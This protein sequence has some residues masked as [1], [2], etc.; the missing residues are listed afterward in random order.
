MTLKQ[1]ASDIAASAEAE[2]K[3]TLKSAKAEAK[4]IVSQA[5]ARASSISEDAAGK[6]GKEA[7]QISKELVASA[8]QSNQKEILIA[9]RVELDATLAQSR[10]QLGDASLG[11]RGSLL[12]HLVKQATS[13]G[14][15]KMVLRPTS[16]DRS[17]LTDA[18]KAFSMGEDVDGLGGF[19][20]EAEDGSVSFDMRFDTLLENAWV[21]QRASINETLFG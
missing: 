3:A 5:E 1:L 21:D 11:G 6:A 10:S 4:D 16:I 8:R 18:A 13:I 2:A 12:K 20:L 7:D 9:R 15:G 17:A 19:I 14:E